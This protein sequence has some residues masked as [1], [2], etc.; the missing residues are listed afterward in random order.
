MV[1]VLGHSH[2]GGSVDIIPS[3]VYTLASFQ[4][5][6]TKRKVTIKTMAAY[7][8][9]QAGLLYAANAST[10]I[11]LSNVVNLQVVPPNQGDTV[12]DAV[13]HC[14]AALVYG[15]S[16]HADTTPPAVK[17]HLTSDG[18]RLLEKELVYQADTG[19][20]QNCI[21]THEV[22][23]IKALLFLVSDKA[24]IT[25]RVTYHYF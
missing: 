24:P 10:P 21:S 11:H 8:T 1:A 18:Q 12:S 14:L 16:S 19:S 2:S 20:G 22:L 9:E 17:L 25:S 15:N 7:L 3:P 23:L 13:E 5:Q 4:Q 6:D